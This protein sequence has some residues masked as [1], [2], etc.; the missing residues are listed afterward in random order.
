MN[1]NAFRIFIVIACTILDG[2]IQT[3]CPEDPLPR[4]VVDRMR[5]NMSIQDI[6]ESN[7]LSKNNVYVKGSSF[8]SQTFATYLFRN[9]KKENADSRQCLE[10][11][12][13]NFQL[14]VD[15]AHEEYLWLARRETDEDAKLHQ[16]HHYINF[17]HDTI[18][19]LLEEH[20]KKLATIQPLPQT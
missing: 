11:R 5:Q 10:S 14:L 18:D 12:C 13:Q 6:I 9:F 3:S 15:R 7:P 2:K 17:I 19:E 16:L 4:M 8:I 1:F 20:K